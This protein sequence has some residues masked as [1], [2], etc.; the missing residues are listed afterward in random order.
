MLKPSV[1][2]L[3]AFASLTLCLTTLPGC[4]QRYDDSLS[5]YLLREDVPV[6]ALPALS[7]LELSPEPLI[8]IDDIVSY[9]RESHV[10]RLTDVAYERLSRLHVP[11]QG[12]AFALCLGH[13]P[14]Y[15]GAFWTPVS[16]IPYDGVAIVK[17]MDNQDG[18]IRIQ[19]GYPSP[20]FF[21]G[22]DPRSDPGI[23]KSLTSAG[24]LR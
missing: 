1:S 6:S 4:T 22:T 23:M 21:K 5:I 16:S 2:L 20:Q 14:V 7:H 19:L 17:E 12:R 15:T 9:G 3:M 10:I 18:S 24:K 11:V 13:R 8:S